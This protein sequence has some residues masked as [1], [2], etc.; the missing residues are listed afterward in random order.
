MFM[1]FKI[2]EMKFIFQAFKMCK[3]IMQIIDNFTDLIGLVTFGGKNKNQFSPIMF[4]T[5]NPFDSL[6]FKCL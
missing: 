4:C 3:K 2:M 1:C 6:I 5:Q